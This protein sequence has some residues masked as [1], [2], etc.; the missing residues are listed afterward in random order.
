MQA[1]GADSVDEAM[2]IA[3]AAGIKPE[4]VPGMLISS[5][6]MPSD[7]DNYEKDEDQKEPKLTRRQ[8]LGIDPIAPELLH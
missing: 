4:D 7:K 2:S 1:L 3:Q 5:G 8:Q 6:M